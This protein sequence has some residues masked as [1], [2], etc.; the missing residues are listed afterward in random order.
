[1]ES[2]PLRNRGRELEA[3]HELEWICPPLQGEESFQFEMIA[4][5]QTFI[6]KCRSRSVAS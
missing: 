6:A 4:R 5:Q 1:M 3:D 2:D